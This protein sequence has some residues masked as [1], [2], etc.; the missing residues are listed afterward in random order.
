MIGCIIQARMGSSRLPGKVLM[1]LDEKNTVL[2]YVVNQ[3]SQSKLVNKIIIA[4]TDL[5][6]DD[7]IQKTANELGIECFRGSSDNVLDRYYECA[8]KFGLNDILRI[9]SDCPLIDSDIVD[10][11]IEKYLTKDFDYVSNT[12]IRTYPIGMDSEIFMD[13]IAKS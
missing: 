2:E 1:K 7:V 8:K 6:Q 11:V 12:L 3:I 4:T 5:E 10:K 9:T 13:N